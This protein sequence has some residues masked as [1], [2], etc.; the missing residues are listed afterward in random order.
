MSKH[1]KAISS[2]S[3]TATLAV[4]L[5]G[6]YVGTAVAEG[7]VTPAQDQAME[8]VATRAKHKMANQFHRR[9]LLDGHAEFARLEVAPDA[10]EAPQRRVYVKSGNRFHPAN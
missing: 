3:A 4:A 1:S 6:G 8:R 2:F 9:Q 5:A 7:G 10:G